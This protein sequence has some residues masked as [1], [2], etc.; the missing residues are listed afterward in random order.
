MKYY[1]PGCFLND[2]TMTTVINLNI[3]NFFRLKQNNYTVNDVRIHNNFS[4]KKQGESKRNDRVIDVTPYSRALDIRKD[5]MAHNVQG[6]EGKASQARLISGPAAI[7]KTY[8][9]RGNAVQI[10][11]SKGT[12]VDSYV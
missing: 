1:L 2:R 4:E 10:Y 3:L 11:D 9:H 5:L 8:D 12:Y 6:P 7:D